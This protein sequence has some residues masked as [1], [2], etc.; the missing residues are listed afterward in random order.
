MEMQ[1]C[2]LNCRKFKS[3]RL[4]TIFMVTG[5]VG[6]TGCAGKPADTQASMAKPV[7]AC[8]QQIS[9]GE[10]MSLSLI[11]QQIQ[12]GQYYSALAELAVLPDSSPDSLLM[13]ADSY[14]KL[15]KWADA[16]PLYTRL[17]DT[18]LSGK[19][20][21]GLGLIAAYQ[22]KV[23]PAVKLL[24]KAARVSPVSANI[25]N[26]LGFLMLVTGQDSLAYD[27]LRTAL[28]LNPD[29]QTAARNL[30]FLLL[31]THRTAQAETL[32]QRYRWA[33]QDQQDMLA[34]IARFR[35]LDLNQ[36][37]ASRK[38]GTSVRKRGYS[39][40]TQEAWQ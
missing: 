34:A 40:L 31:K 14:R 11:Q 25:R 19:A 32:A 30:W 17:V 10:G 9:A 8:G 6:L 27:E 20:Y 24:E 7:G 33:E 3:L 18:C 21:H 13:Q 35:P 16:E 38:G 22:G 23:S 1:P 29:H 2:I 4:A 37:P 12:K 36:D 39:L 26:D 5:L 15:G 28:E